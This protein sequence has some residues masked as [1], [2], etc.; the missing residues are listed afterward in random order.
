MFSKVQHPI[1]EICVI[2]CNF[3][4]NTVAVMQIEKNIIVLTCKIKKII[5]LLLIY[6]QIT[7]YKNNKICSYLKI[8]WYFNL[9]NS[10]CKIKLAD[11]WI[12]H[13]TIK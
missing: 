7:N 11:Q 10:I 12:T 1:A 3:A 13:D 9:S 5:C 6:T 2:V 8:F 4:K